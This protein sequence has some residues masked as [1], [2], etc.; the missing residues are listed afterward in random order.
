MK[1]TAVILLLL[2]FASLLSAHE[3]VQFKKYET[4]HQILYFS[5]NLD[6]SVIPRLIKQA[7]KSEEF[8]KDLYG[9]VPQKKIIVVY[10][11]ETD[12]ANGWSRSYLKN[13][14]YLYTFPP[15]RYS[16]L[17]SYTSWE[18]GLHVHEYTHSVQIG[19]TKGFP[20]FFNTLF[21]NLYFPGGMIPRWAL[22]GV[23]IYSESLIEGKGR[24]FSPL[25]KAHFN[26]F[27]LNKNELTLGELSGVSDHWMGGGLPYLFGT[28]FYAY[29]VE[30]TSRK[31]LA[32][33]FDELSDDA[34]PFLV[35]RAAKTTLGSSVRDLYK[36]FIEKTRLD[37]GSQEKNHSG[38]NGSIE[39]FHSVFVDL[40][41]EGYAVSGEKTGKRGIYRFEKGKLKR[42]ASLPGHDSFSKKGS[43]YLFPMNIRHEDR[44]YRF[45]LFLADMNSK[46][47]NKLTLNES[48]VEAAFG[49]N[50]DIFYISFRDG[51]NRIT[52]ISIDGTLLKEWDFPELDS[53]YSLS[54]T[55]DGKRILFTGN[56]YNYEKNMFIFNIENNE[57]TEIRI[58]GDQ[59]SAYFKNDDE[60]IFSSERNGQIVPL[61][62]DLKEKKLTQLYRPASIALFPKVIDDEIYFIAFDNDGYYPASWKL[63]N[64]DLG[65]VP[66]GIFEPV[67]RKNPEKTEEI[68]LKNAKFYEGM[69]P[70]LII[71]DYQG[72]SSSHTVGFTIHGES[73]DTQRF[74]DISYYKT[75]GGSGRHF[76]L[77]NYFDQALWPG[78]RWYFSYSRDETRIGRNY[79]T[80]ASY[81]RFN[82]GISLFSS[83]SS[84]AF[85]LPSRIVKINH[86]IRTSLGLSGT[87]MTVKQFNDPLL[88][89]PKENDRMSLAASFAYGF[90]FSFN[91]G[92]YY[93]FSEMENTSFSLP[94]TINISLLDDTR[95]IIFSPA[96]KLSFLILNNGKL[97]FIT[98]NS[99]YMRFLS[100]SYFLLG[101]SELDIEILNLNTFIYGGSSNVTVRG[102]NY[103]AA[104][105]RHVY[106]SNNELRFHIFSL[107]Q[108]FNT[109]PLM[110]KNVQGALFFD[111]GGGSHDINMFNDK[112]IA[113]LGAELKLYSVW[114]YRVPII[115][116]FGTAYGLTKS[117][118]L[119]FYFSLGNS[120]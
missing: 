101:G 88:I 23:A 109:F 64:I 71:P 44:Y 74:Y 49:R 90:S 95:S 55:S 77:I 67:E 29:L 68:P 17:S 66:D 80:K 62:L 108:G 103:G 100:D 96:M 21:G 40:N 7:E 117:G 43:V 110:F 2:I 89:T 69:F 115:F 1:K 15:E 51:I 106:H 10:D 76:A 61:S 82:S 42:T 102:Y 20:K 81:D 14:I 70:A 63:E 99:L 79:K 59:Y 87:D 113:G 11:R 65:K 75:F 97:G 60:I 46:S 47:V 91:P 31:Q 3:T 92:S 104:G 111:I 45:E 12:M 33:F 50:D 8:I 26:S 85:I 37:I 4:K 6:S 25:Y 34:L 116:T 39:R 54:L 16:T 58:D 57:L 19:N 38:E 78:F 13:T 83:S 18:Q 94:L 32:D 98:R 56:I 84:P 48:V 36:E 28:Y 73:N 41:S 107:N 24:L 86:S 72:S 52:R 9:W 27:F 114:W 119:N 30:K 120:F 53:I 35:N 112:F 93:L 5:S 105:G 22:E 118:Q